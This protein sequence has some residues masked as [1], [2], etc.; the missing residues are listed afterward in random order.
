MSE[1]ADFWL[2]SG[3][4]L[5]DRGEDGRLKITDEFLKA[6]LARPELMPPAG[7]CI[8]EREIHRQMMINPRMIIADSQLA[9]IAE[10]DA[11]DNWA[12][13][14]AWRDFLLESN[15]LEAAYLKLAQG[16]QKFPHL[17]INQLVQVILR[18][19]L[20][21][22]DDAFMVRVAE[23][24]FRPQRLTLLEGCII[25]A[26]EE[27]I[28]QR[29]SAP[30]S[31]L[32]SLLGLAAGAEIEV[33]NEANEHQ[34]W[35]RSDSFDFALDLTG[36]R[37]ALKAVGNLIVRWVR[38]LLGIELSVL[39]VTELK[40]IGL[41]WYIGLDAEA[42]LIGDTLWAAGALDAAKQERLIGLYEMRFVDA[43]RMD[44]R[45]SGA[46]TY[47]IMAMS[48][49]WGLRL[50]PQNLLAGLPLRQLDAA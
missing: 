14:I 15:T 10:H 7:A 5:L 11:R 33:L 1:S 50:K 43:A 45:L 23:M 20:N 18:N 21:G 49:D 28:S 2:T 22:C 47:I 17:F 8:A 46:A 9:A 36:G 24:F 37:R 12:L 27:A 3:H 48:P 4:H 29:A 40:N 35:E 44:P 39:P 19:V 16:K 32:S 25:A 13:M 30:L 41:T 38:H 6:Y 34:Y 26:D 42:T 31:P